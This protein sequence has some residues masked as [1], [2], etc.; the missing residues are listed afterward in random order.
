MHTQHRNARVHGDNVPVGHVGRYRAAA[1]LIHLAQSGNLPDDPGLIQSTAHEA[2]G[3][4]GGV[5]GSAFAPGTGVLANGR[6]V[7]QLGIVPLVAG[8]GKIGVK[9]VGHIGRQTEGLGKAVLQLDPLDIAQAAHEMLEVVA[10]HTGN[11]HGADFLL[12]RQN[13]DRGFCGIFDVK[14]GVQ[15]GIGADPVVMAVSTQKT[16]V[17]AYLPA[18]PGGH[19]R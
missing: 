12:V 16:S 17:Q 6:T 8:V 13:A 18:A 10:L 1:A 9:G 7:V 11:A 4:G 3:L 5:G 2:H 14:N 19:Y 15:L